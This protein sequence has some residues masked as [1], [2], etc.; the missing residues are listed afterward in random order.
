MRYIN[1]TEKL[2]CLKQAK[3]KNMSWY[4]F[5]RDKHEDYKK[6]K[7]KLIEMQHGLCVY[8]ESK[9]NNK[10][11]IEHFKCRSQFKKDTYEWDNL[12]VSC[13]SD[14]HC[15]KFKDSSNNPKYQIDN[16]IKPDLDNPSDYFVFSD[17]GKIVEKYDLS[18]SDKYKATETIRVLNLNESELINIRKKFY[19]CW[20]TIIL[21]L[22]NNE[23]PII[24]DINEN[25]EYSAELKNIIEKTGNQHPSVREAVIK[26]YVSHL[27]KKE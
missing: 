14:S 7:N 3:K 10:S 18:T 5:Q 11:H 13:D 4:I 1:R 27:I 25:I 21:D 19:K 20:Q 2:G 6:V 8:C 15:G 9:L 16:L 12:F 26:I 24:V 17:K 23:V 22:I